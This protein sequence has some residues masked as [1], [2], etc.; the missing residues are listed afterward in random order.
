VLAQVEKV[1]QARAAV[2]KARIQSMLATRSVLTE[3][4]WNKLKDARMA[5]MGSHRAFR[6]RGFQ[7]GMRRGTPPTPPSK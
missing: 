4:Q 1:S 3:E 2:E 7:R 6:Q 5:R